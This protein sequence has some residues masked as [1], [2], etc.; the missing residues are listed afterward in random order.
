[1]LTKG[2]NSAVSNM[3]FQARAEFQAQWGSVGET[4]AAMEALYD[5]C[6]SESQSIRDSQQQNTAVTE[7]IKTEPTNILQQ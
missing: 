3:I 4:R 5:S 2:A 6:C 1:M 7:G